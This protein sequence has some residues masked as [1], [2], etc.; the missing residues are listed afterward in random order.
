MGK[1]KVQFTLTFYLKQNKEVQ[2]D[3]QNFEIFI[4]LSLLPSL[5][6]GKMLEKLRYGFES[7]H[8]INNFF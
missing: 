5:L 6:P 2:L 7:I 1:E 4:F 3:L 8:V